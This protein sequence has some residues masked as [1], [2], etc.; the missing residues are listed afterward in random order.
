MDQNL[1]P[2]AYKE[3]SIMEINQ[4]LTELPDRISEKELAWEQ[5]KINEDLRKAELI[6]NIDLQKYK[7]QEQREAYVNGDSDFVKARHLTAEVKV[8]YHKLIN[9]KDCVMEIARN[10]RAELKAQF[11]T[12]EE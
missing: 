6:E 4:E 7:N 9:R 12:V 8:E 3:M 10:K 5:A 2:V 1:S 11:G